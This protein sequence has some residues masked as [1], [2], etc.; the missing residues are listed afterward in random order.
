MVET[1][2]GSLSESCIVSQE[3]LTVSHSLKESLN[4]PFCLQVLLKTHPD[5]IHLHKPVPHQ[6]LPNMDTSDATVLLKPV[7]QQSLLLTSTYKDAFRKRQRLAQVRPWTS[8]C[9]DKYLQRRIPTTKTFCAG[10]SLKKP[11]CQQVLPE[12]HSNYPIYLAST[13]IQHYTFKG[14]L[15]FCHLKQFAVTL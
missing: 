14:A 5:A 15:S 12:T 7:S 11:F 2:S 8:P 6:A 9:A 10:R 1:L 3:S 13:Q 4:K